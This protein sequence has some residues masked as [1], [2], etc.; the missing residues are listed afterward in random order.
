MSEVEDKAKGSGVF[1]AL[2]ILNIILG[3]F[4]L[5]SPFMAGIVTTFLLGGIVLV[6]GIVELA[7]AFTASNWK[8]GLLKFIGGVL[9]LIVGVIFLFQP[10]KGLAIL[11]WVVAV[12]FLMDG[13]FRMVVAFKVKPERGWGWLLFGGIV[14]TLLGAYILADWPISSLWIIGLLVGI[15]MLFIGWAMIFAG[16]AAKSIAAQEAK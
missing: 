11:S 12:F 1:I 8:A 4:L 16:A 6:G 9:A 10:L 15:R 7:H 5:G 13:L 2:G 3:M 14:T